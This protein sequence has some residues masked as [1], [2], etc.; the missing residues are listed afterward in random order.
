MSKSAQELRDYLKIDEVGSLT[1]IFEEEP[2]P[3][4]TFITDKNYLNNPPL[5]QTQYDT[6]RHLEQIYLPET[7]PL[8]MEEFGPHWEPVRFVNFGYIM[9]GKGSG[10]DHVCRITS[11]RAAYLLLCL[12][13]PQ[14]YFGMPVQ[15]YIHTLNVAASATQ[16]HRAFFMP[17]RN[18]VKNAKCFSN[19]YVQNE[20]GE[21][22]RS[23]ILFKKQVELVSGHSMAET[24][25]GLNILLGIAD[26]ISAFKT[27]EE[28]DR[29]AKTQGGREPVKTA[30]SILKMIRTSARTRF[31]RCFKMAAISYP[32]YK[33]DAI[34][35]LVALGRL[36][37]QK[38]EEK[39]RIYVSGPLSTWD[40]NPRVDSK[41][42]F[43]EDYD[44]DPA[45]ARAMYECDPDFATS[46]FFRNDAAILN[47]FQK[48]QP[49]PLVVQYYWGVDK[50]SMEFEPLAPDQKKGWQV[51][52]S[53]SQDLYPIQGALYAIH[54]DLAISGDRAGIA[55][56]HVRNWKTGE[57]EGVGGSIVNEPRPIVQL[58][59]VT[60]FEADI[61]AQP[62]PRE[63]Q[64]RWAR[65]LAYELSSR[66]FVIGLY[67]FDNFQSFDS[68]QILQSRGIE[69]KRQST[70]RNLIPWNTLR[71]VMYDGRLEAYYRERIVRELQSLMLL[72]NNK[73]DHPPNSS[74]DEA[75]SVAGAVMGALDLGGSETEDRVRADREAVELIGTVNV[76]GQPG[77]SDWSLGGGG[78]WNF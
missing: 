18:L 19:T 41:E 1:D 25:E 73:V 15:D 8:L 62:Q 53:Y 54:C 37:N 21:P 33:G 30:D 78:D 5:S 24:L 50:T 11:A 65:K 28:A 48:K 16:A 47:A 77:K 31:P 76:S 66:G 42:D 10:K 36:D 59:F 26:E 34:Q 40:V 63:I 17:L 60:A 13:N 56:A 68:I 9:W 49:D 72:P 45:M 52:F 7:Y 38:Y 70:D 75:D 14:K 58:D 55:M 6:V 23:S 61:A 67:T 27:K 2:V 3:L 39:S 43:R 74:K 71:D 12:K 35:Q 57:W 44:E 64:I 69:S 22:G 29:F 46:R 4:T 20:D 51:R 32:R